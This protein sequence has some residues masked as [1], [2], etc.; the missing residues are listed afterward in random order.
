MTT[1]ERIG[2]EKPRSLAGTDAMKPLS[3]YER[4][5]KDVLKNMNRLKE[6]RLAREA[7]IGA[8]LSSGAKPKDEANDESTGRDSIDAPNN[9]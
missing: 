1:D 5:S 8:C 7:E 3:E 2:K 6:L 4:K 9:R